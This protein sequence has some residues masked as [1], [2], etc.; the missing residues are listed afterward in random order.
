MSN[1]GIVVK[2]E[3]YS[4]ILYMLV[5]LDVSNKGI[6]VKLA[7]LENICCIVVTLAVS[8]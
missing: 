2:L 4:N 6:V 8:L 7:Q 5:T 1:C 3:Q